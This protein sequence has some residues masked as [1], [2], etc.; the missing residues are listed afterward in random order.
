MKLFVGNVT[1]QNHEFMY[2]LIAGAQKIHRQ[3]IMAGR[4]IQVAGDLQPEEVNSIVDQHAKYGMLQAS[5]I[6]RAKRFHGLCYSI[7][8]PISSELLNYLRDH[9][10]GEKD[11]EGRELRKLAAI[12]SNDILET[13]LREN[14][15]PEQV[16][17]FE[18]TIQEDREI[19]SDL[20]QLAEG[21]RVIRN[22]NPPAPS[23]KARR[24]AA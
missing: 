3:M 19:E 23:R 7:D 21:L 10:H 9:N 15:R 18:V 24:K 2:R 14:D 11:E 8:K 5:E 1:A 16:R 6:P 12:T 22:P 20:P 4:Q 13:T 17:Q